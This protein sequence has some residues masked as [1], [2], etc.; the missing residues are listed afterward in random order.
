MRKNRKEIQFKVGIFIF[1]GII[2]LSTSILLLGTNQTL[3]SF[4]TKYKMKFQQVHGLFAGSVVTVNGMPAGN[5]ISVSFM[6]ETGNV[7]VTVAIVRQFISVITDRSEATLLTKG[8]LGDKYVSITSPGKIGAV[9]PADSY[10][11]TRQDKDMLSLLSNQIEIRK[12]SAVIDEAL[13]LLQRANTEKTV[14]K[15][16][17]F[18]SDENAKD[19]KD[20]L[21][22]FKSILR[23]IDK[24]EGTAGALINN[25]RIYNTILSYLGQR[26]YH[27]FVPDLVK[28]AKKKK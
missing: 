19:I 26:P 14:Q 27:K 2:A 28:E 12:I 6:K 18:F 24:G 16:S 7:Q 10:I 3:F 5:V 4:T 25:K 11:P 1:L 22:H 20:I 9:L 21:K 15:I 23:K 8:I 13:L 17:S